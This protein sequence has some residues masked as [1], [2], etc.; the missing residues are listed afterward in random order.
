MSGHLREI[1]CGICDRLQ[2]STNLAGVVGDC[3]IKWTG[4]RRLLVRNIMVAIASLGPTACLLLIVVVPKIS[5]TTVLI[6][7][8]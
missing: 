2:I 7:I 1:A 5:T 6:L 4:G 8:L 3:A